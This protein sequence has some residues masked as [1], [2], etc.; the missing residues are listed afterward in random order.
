M[1][2]DHYP[3]THPKCVYVR[4][5]DCKENVHLKVDFETKV[6][7]KVK[8]HDCKEIQCKH[9]RVGDLVYAELQF[10]KGEEFED[11]VSIEV[12]TPDFIHERDDPLTAYKQI[13]GSGPQ[14]VVVAF[15]LPHKTPR[16]YP[17]ARLIR[18]AKFTAFQPAIPQ[19]T[20]KIGVTHHRSLTN[21][22]KTLGLYAWIRNRSKAISFN[23]REG[24]SGYGYRDFIDRVLC[25]TQ[26]KSNSECSVASEKLFPQRVNWVVSLTESAPMNC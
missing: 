10:G 6:E 23:T 12:L 3:D 20:G 4:E 25:P 18:S 26:Q 16:S 5:E 7:L 19:I 11:L 22:Q 17:P 8:A 2:Y 21:P 14:E 13:T 15:G 1:T 9:P 24:E